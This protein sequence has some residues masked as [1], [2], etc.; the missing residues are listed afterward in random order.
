MGSTG[1]WGK[2]FAPNSYLANFPPDSGY[3]RTTVELGYV[4]LALFCILMFV[5][6]KTGIDHYYLIKDPELKSYCL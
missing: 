6:I 3:V 1:E 2:K 4:G 5:I